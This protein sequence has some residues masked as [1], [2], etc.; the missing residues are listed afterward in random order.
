MSPGPEAAL[1][2]AIADFARLAQFSF[3]QDCLP[4]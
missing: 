1:S 3:C 2:D 4:R